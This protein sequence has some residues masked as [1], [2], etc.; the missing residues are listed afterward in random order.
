MEQMDFSQA[1]PTT[2]NV[3]MMTAIMALFFIP[4]I[5]HFLFVKPRGGKGIYALWGMI[6]FVVIDMLFVSGANFLLVVIPPVKA[7][8]EQ[9][10]VAAT[11]YSIISMSVIG[12]LLKFL[13]VK[14]A[15]SKNLGEGNAMELGLG[16][17]AVYAIA[18][19]GVTMFMNYTVSMAITGQGMETILS[20]VGNDAEGAAAWIEAYQT[21]INTS[22][23]EYMVAAANEC[24]WT[25]FH[26]LSCLVFYQVAKGKV[27]YTGLLAII[28]LHG[29]ML[30]PKAL[31]G[32]DIIKTEWITFG[33]MLVL[34]GGFAKIVWDRWLNPGE[35]TGKKIK[36]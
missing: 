25:V 27:K 35:K 32:N 7:F 10:Q 34:V 12:E 33:I 28:A 9:N 24:L 29:V 22:S 21:L 36:K 14:F 26:M 30:I 18:F 31:A 4:I 2:A 3:S 20:E 23:F 11:A 16:Y 8:M 17:G 5:V 13:V 19:T 6:S 15:A 1:I